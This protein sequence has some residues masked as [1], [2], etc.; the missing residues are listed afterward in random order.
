M[1]RIPSSVV[2][3]V[4]ADIPETTARYFRLMVANPKP[5]YS[6]AAYGVP[7]TVPTGTRI[8]ESAHQPTDNLR[9]GLGLLIFGQWFTRHET[10]AEYAR[11]WTDYLARS[12]Y[13]L[14]QGKA[15][16]DVLWYYGE[17]TNVT[18]EHEWALPDVPDS[19]SYDF[20][21]PHALL[22][23]PAVNNY[24]VI[25]LGAHTETMSIEV[26]RKLHERVCCGV[27]LIGKEPVQMAGLGDNA[28]EFDRL[29]AGIWHAGRSN[30]WTGSVAEGMK[31]SGVAPDLVAAPGIR[32]VHRKD[33]DKD[34]YWVR[35]FSGK[36]VDS[37]ITLREAS[38]TLS[39]WNPVN[40]KQVFG[41]L[42][43]GKLHLEADEALFI[44]SDPSAVP[45]KAPATL[46]SAGE[47]AIITPWTVSFEGLDAPAGTRK[48]LQLSSLTES[49]EAAVKYFSGTVTYKNTFTLSKKNMPE[50]LFIDLGQ[51]GQMAD[52]FV[53]GK[54]VDFLWK[55]PYRTTF[56]GKLK[57][58]K[59]T[60][61][62]K[63]INLWVNRL[64]G[65]A[66]IGA[67]GHTYAPVPFYRADSPLLPSGLMGP[68]KLELMK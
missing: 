48:W 27:F 68:V 7:V 22:N 58:G 49:G 32:F 12:C 66:Q 31:R 46:R 50:A 39:V 43:D 15:V 23:A 5:D 65:D 34:I 2:H 52:V 18:A 13:M 61:E 51:V 30:V 9:P 62:I 10:W 19:Y 35:N 3:Q 33:G 24:K 36:P 59:N 14:Q 44:V 29:V 64:I 11:Y 6:Y 47:V 17:D 57:P 38:G 40:G 67:E 41:A 8:H 25:A 37:D 4:T 54:H 26:L 55:A 53:N 56:E 60:I 1:C 28:A 63:V 16:S 21:S 42:C 20:C 45:A